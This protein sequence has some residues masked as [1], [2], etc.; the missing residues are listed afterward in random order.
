MMR[1]QRLLRV[2]RNACVCF[3]SRRARRAVAA[4]TPAPVASLRW[5][6]GPAPIGLCTVVLEARSDVSLRLYYDIGTGF[7]REFMTELVPDEDGF[8]QAPAYVPLGLL[9]MG[10]E[11][12]QAGATLPAQPL[13]FTPASRFDNLE[14]LFTTRTARHVPWWLWPLMAAVRTVGRLRGRYRATRGAPEQYRAFLRR[15]EPDPEADRAAAALHQQSFAE[16]PGISIL[17]PVYNTPIQWLER[18]IESVRA[19]VYP[20]WQLC[21]ADDASPD[22]A[23]RSTLARYAAM[24]A[25]ICWVSSDRN[26]GIS[27]ASNQALALAT[28]RFVS[29]LDH[30]DEL[31]PLA[32]YWVAAALNEQPDL[33]LIYT[34]EDKIDVR[35]QRYDPHFKPDW[36]P[37]LLESINYVAHLAV[38]RRE[39]VERVG[40]LRSECDG[41]QDYDLTLRVS[42]ETSP[43]RIRHL[44]VIAYHWRAI[45][46]ST[47][48]DLGEKS[49]PHQAGLRAL[50]DR[51]A[52]RPGIII[53][54]GAFPTSYRVRFSLPDPPPRVSAIVPTR[55]GYPHLQKSILGLLNATDYADLE[56]LLVDNQSTDPDTLAFF[57][58]VSEDSRVRVLRYDAPFN[59]SAI[60]NFAANQA[61]GSVLLLLNDDTEIIHPDWLQEM[62]GIC[63]RDDVGAVG[64]KLYYTDDTVQHGGVALGIGGVAG[65]VHLAYPRHSAG[66]MGRLLLRQQLSAV[67][68]ACL[69]VEKRKFDAVS[70]LD[71][72]HLAVAFNDIDL[73]LRLGERGWRTVWTPWAQLYHHESKTRGP[74]TAPE[75]KARFERETQYMKRRWGA[76][77]RH[78]PCY[79]RHFSS[80]RQDYALAEV[81]RPWR[82]WMEQAL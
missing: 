30:D 5:L 37:D 74:D 62:V 10:L 78:D 53:E 33:D 21:L 52:H 36:N 1:M 55:D 56:V 65:H 23:I 22:P 18:A 57:S 7:D 4:D 11:P 25:R 66:Y 71:A 82:P 27:S 81:P 39:L 2:L 73:C 6:E 72:E 48:L 80:M 38:Y 67:T 76:L 24:D 3:G 75:K 69:V 70:G 50:A 42:A 46:G 20:H 32:L 29:F 17:V 61:T 26:G 64:A 40:G 16:A 31:H 49:Y 58:S 47:A 54:S 13:V 8:I 44:P 28:G 60:N 34:D 9:R 45:P 14:F 63:L 59:Y 68:A 35:G 77:L 19:Q 15:L 79:S 12:T 43:Q 41:S 51:F